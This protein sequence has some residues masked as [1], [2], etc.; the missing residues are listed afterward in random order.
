VLTNFWL[1]TLAIVC[2]PVKAAPY[3]CGEHMIGPVARASDLTAFVGRR[4]PKVELFGG[5][6]GV[7][8]WRKGAG[9]EDFRTLWSA[10]GPGLKN[11]ILGVLAAESLLRVNDLPEGVCFGADLV[12][13]AVVLWGMGAGEL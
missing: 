11:L 9:D 6:D 7:L 1:S 3:A 5:A 2:D 8:G 12:N 4:G 13:Q 10:S